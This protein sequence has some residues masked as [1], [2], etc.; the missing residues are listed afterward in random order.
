MMG[1]EATVSAASTVVIAEAI[2]TLVRVASDVSRNGAGLDLVYDSSG[3][4]I[5][6]DLCLETAVLSLEAGN[7]LTSEIV[8][9]STSIVLTCSYDITGVLGILV[10]YAINGSLSLAAAI[11][12]LMTKGVEA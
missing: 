7:L 10:L 1:L 5:I 2:S 11:T 8:K 12:E 6:G 4:S 3:L 9:N